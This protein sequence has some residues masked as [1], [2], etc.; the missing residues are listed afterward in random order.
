MALCNR[1]VAS[2]ETFL[3]IKKSFPKL[4]SLK[5]M[6]FMLPLQ[7]SMTVT[8]PSTN[9]YS[10][11]HQPFPEKPV[12]IAKFDDVIELMKSLVK[13]RKLTIIGDNGQAYSFLCKPDDDLRKDARL[14]DFN[15]MI[16]KL[17]KSNSEARKRS[18]CMLWV[19]SC[20]IIC[21]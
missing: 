14:M 16:N 7:S 4:D 10:N 6:N 12:K 1:R 8:L 5:S 11:T 13:P 20:L 21:Y 18:L 15:S 2:D 17:L 19:F 9:R 3:S